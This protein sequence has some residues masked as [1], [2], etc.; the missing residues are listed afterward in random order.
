MP[1]CTCHGH[2]PCR[3]VTP[4][5]IWEWI[6]LPNTGRPQTRVFNQMNTGLLIEIDKE[7]QRRTKNETVTGKTILWTGF[8]TY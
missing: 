6:E 3:D 8:H 4:E 7:L 1:I 5:T 2:A